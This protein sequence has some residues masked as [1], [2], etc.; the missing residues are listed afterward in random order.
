[1]NFIKKSVSEL[2]LYQVK[3]DP[4]LIKLNQNES[5]YD[6]PPLIKQAV[7]NKL[8]RSPGNRYPD[9]EMTS[10]RRQLSSF[11]NQPSERI[12]IGSGS[13]EIILAIF[14][15]VCRPG[16]RI[17]VLDPSF[18]MYS[19][20]AR[21]FE[22]E[23]V[24]VPA[25]SDFKTDPEKLVEAAQKSRIIFLASPNNPTGLALERKWIVDLLEN[26]STL[27]VIDEAYHEFHRE[28]VLPL[29][30]KF[31]NLIV[32]R[33]FSKAF[34]A[35][36]IRLGYAIGNE[37]IISGLEKAKLPFS[38]G[39]FSQLVAEELLHRYQV[40]KMH[41][42]KIIAERE[43]LLFGLLGMP[44]LEVIP[45]QANFILFRSTRVSASDFYRSL[46]RAGVLVR[47]FEDRE[48]LQDWLR[49]TVGRPEE[50]QIFLRT[51]AQIIDREKGE[52]GRDYF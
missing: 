10:L 33:T 12:I 5:P 3:Q 41:I 44:H 47:N 38:V 45:S 39:L 32:L 11:T 52:N 17:A 23:I 43:R 27:V 31:S 37:E 49:V 6:V 46:L 19:R 9:A 26:S 50:S 20:L 14:L 2:P 1:M 8:K 40:C 15:G 25:E 29:I 36:G 51:V 35:A 18:S 34:G 28:T 13:N 30:E 42:E 22:A 16:D 24:R 21:T 4:N 48:G 7:W